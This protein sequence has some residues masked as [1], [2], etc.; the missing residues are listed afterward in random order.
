MEILQLKDIKTVPDPVH[1]YS[2]YVRE[3]NTPIV[4]DNGKVGITL[5]IYEP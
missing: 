1:S 4:I 2:S 3:S 5:Y